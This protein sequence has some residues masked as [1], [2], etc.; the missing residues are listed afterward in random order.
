MTIAVKT[1]CMGKHLKV[2]SDVKFFDYDETSHEII[3]QL[4]SPVEAR[5][6]I[7]VEEVKILSF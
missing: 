7:N 6:I 5:S 2:F 4:Y 1:K 3:I